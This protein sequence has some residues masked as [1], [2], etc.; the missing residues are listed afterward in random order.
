M[1]L[2]IKNKVVV[3]LIKKTLFVCSYL[4]FNSLLSQNNLVTNGS[5]QKKTLCPLNGGEIDKSIGWF[6]PSRI[7]S[8]S[9]F[10]DGCNTNVVGI[11][12]NQVGFQFGIG[13]S[14]YAGVILYTLPINP[15]LVNYRE[16]VETKLSY[17]LKKKL[18]LLCRIL[19]FL[20]RHP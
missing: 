14:S 18:Y 10:F 16:Y 15:N 3:R 8:S 1:I 11:P 4:S 20:S 17:S 9:E 2:S 7:F 5:F 19:C 6:Q 13:D 12:R